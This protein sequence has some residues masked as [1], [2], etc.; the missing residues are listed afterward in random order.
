MAYGRW[1]ELEQG[2]RRGYRRGTTGGTWIARRR[3]EAGISEGILLAFFS[4]CVL[5]RKL[6]PTFEGKGESVVRGHPCP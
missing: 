6:Q 4:Q 3:D 2:L 1:R 5:Y